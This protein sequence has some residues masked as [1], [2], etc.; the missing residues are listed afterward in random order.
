MIQSHACLSNLETNAELHVAVVFLLA[1]P[2]VW[3]HHEASIFMFK[4]CF[5]IRELTF[6]NSFSRMHAGERGVGWGWGALQMLFIQI[7]VYSF[8]WKAKQ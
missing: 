5:Y 4:N 7:M 3:T 1:D 6:F 8:S 2:R